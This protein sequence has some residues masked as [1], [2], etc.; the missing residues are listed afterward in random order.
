M[1]SHRHIDAG[2]PSCAR[3]SGAYRETPVNLP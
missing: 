1:L 2:A 3:D